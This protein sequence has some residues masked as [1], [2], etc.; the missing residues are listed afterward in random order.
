MNVFD[1]DIPQLEATTAEE[2]KTK[3]E[4]AQPVSQNFAFIGCGA[5][6][7]RLTDAFYRIG[8]RRCMV[9]N[10]C[11]QDQDGL[12]ENLEYVNTQ[13]G[14]SAKDPNISRTLVLKP[15]VRVQFL[16]FFK[17]ILGNDFDRV[18]V[19]LGAGGG[20]GSGMGPELIKLLKEYIATNNLEAKVGCIMSL[21]QPSEGSR[22]CTNALEAY[23]N[24]LKQGPLPLIVIDNARVAK[25]RKSTIKSLYPDAN[26]SAVS[27]LH[28]LNV[29]SATP[30]FQTLDSADFRS[31]LNSGM[32]TFGVVGINNWKEGS[33]LIAKTVM[34]TF[35]SATLAD[36]DAS[37]ATQGLCV[38]V[39]GSN[40]LEKF[41][42]DELMEGLT[43]LRNSSKC[44][45]M[46]LHPAIYENTVAGKEDSL[47]VY[48]G[49]GGLRP[50]EGVLQ[51]LAKIGNVQVPKL[52]QFLGIT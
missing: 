36:V 51:S 34:E 48:V 45:S 12:S 37:E 2:A 8:Y 49:L 1:T 24:I 39:A 28:T 33:D 32:I 41:S 15:D 23:E 4:L 22:V 42:N 26:S 9:I 52:A 30:S 21:P 10:T 3:D 38:M 6:G 17:E 5:A 27:L 50:N 40:V 35:R 47:A 25:L 29:L 31:F 43:L 18:F 13:L 7:G 16:S 11:E 44:Q 20:T 19:C 14:G 46:V